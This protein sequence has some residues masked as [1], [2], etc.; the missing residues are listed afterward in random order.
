ML[1]ALTAA[2]QSSPEPNSE[3]FTYRVSA[4][5]VSEDGELL[6]G[7]VLQCFSDRT[8]VG[9]QD[10][11]GEVVVFISDAYCPNEN[12]NKKYIGSSGTHFDSIRSDELNMGLF[13]LEVLNQYETYLKCDLPVPSPFEVAKNCAS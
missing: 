6:S 11:A 9:G 5:E 12:L 7:K 13:K 3:D 10:G 2:C 1:I 8:E 4:G